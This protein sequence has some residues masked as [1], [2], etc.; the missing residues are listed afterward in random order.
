MRVILLFLS[1]YFSF[2]VFAQIQVNQTEFDLGEI[3]L[4]NSDIV[5]FNVQN[6]SSEAVY[7]LRIEAEKQ[8]GFQYTTK[9]FKP[10]AKEGIRIKLNPNKK[11]KIEQTVRL[12]FSSNS[13]PIEIKLNAVVKALPKNNRTACPTFGSSLKPPTGT[14]QPIASIQALDLLLFD[15]DSKQALAVVIVEQ[16]NNEDI[17]EST[18]ATGSSRIGNNLPSRTR[19]SRT[20]KQKNPRLTP[21]ERRNSPSLGTILFGK[22]VVDSTKVDSEPKDDVV[23]EEETIQNK[24]LITD[25]QSNEKNEVEKDSQKEEVKTDK[26]SE[27]LLDDSF[28]PNNIVFLIDASTSMREEQKMDILKKAMIELLEPL[29]AIDYITIVTYSGE[30][31]V[32]VPTSQGNLKEEIAKQI[33]NLQADGSTNAVKGIK[34]AIQ[35]GK[36]NFLEEGNNQIFLA[37]DGAFNIGENNMS[38]RKKIKKTAEE[39]LTITVLGIKNDNWTNKSLKEIAT[40]GAGDLIKIKS[41]RDAGK[42]LQS[43]KRKAMR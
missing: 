16:K 39:G 19:V 25:V 27:N 34:K 37:S 6:I 40:L 33:E 21:E 23:Q 24:P 22:T 38:L 28:K 11:G 41:M 3:S 7:L 31:R 20:P 8:V 13:D 2:A 26:T 36:S 42:V 18:A 32:V 1:I 4:L 14:K 29:R 9:N 43:M 5:D 17:E 35:V 10:G 12:Y 30:A 15:E